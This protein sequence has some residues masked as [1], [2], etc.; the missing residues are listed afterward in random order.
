MNKHKDVIFQCFMNALENKVGE[1]LNEFE[2][3]PI[4]LTLKRFKLAWK[5]LQEE[6]DFNFL[7]QMLLMCN[8]EDLMKDLELSP[9]FLWTYQAQC[10]NSDHSE[11]DKEVPF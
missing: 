5:A 11:F 8:K 1:Q 9:D 10:P 3:K 2:H 6:C 4:P 7:S